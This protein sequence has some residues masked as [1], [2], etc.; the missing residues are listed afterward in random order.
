MKLESLFLSILILLLVRLLLS[1]CEAEVKDPGA[2]QTGAEQVDYMMI[3]SQTHTDE[4][5]E[6]Y[7]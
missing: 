2:E 7:T 5:L 1:Q 6:Q 3:Y 4:G